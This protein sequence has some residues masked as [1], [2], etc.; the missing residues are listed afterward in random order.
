MSTNQS[1]QDQATAYAEAVMAAGIAKGLSPKM[2]AANPGL[3]V[4]A[5]HAAQMRFY[6]RLET[7]VEFKA[8]WVADLKTEIGIK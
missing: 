5:Y 1:T 3:A 8:Q 6:K 4:E 2:I 7:D